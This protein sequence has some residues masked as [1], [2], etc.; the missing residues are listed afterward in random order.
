MFVKF[1]LLFCIVFIVLF[2]LWS[3]RQLSIRKVKISLMPLV[4]HM[5]FWDHKPFTLVTKL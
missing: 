3:N 4:Q 5:F 2:C 1:N